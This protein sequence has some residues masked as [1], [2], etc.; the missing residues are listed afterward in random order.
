[1]IERSNLTYMSSN[2]G[3]QPRPIRLVYLI[4][5][6]PELTNTFIDREIT[7]LRRLGNFDIRIVSI[8]Y[9]RTV[10]SFSAEQKALHQ[11]TTYLLS[12]QWAKFNYLAFSASNIH[13]LFSKPLVYIKT[14][15]ELLSGSRRTFKDWVKTTFYFWQGVYAAYLLRSVPFD[16]LHV[17]FMDRAVLAALVASRL[18]KKTYSFTAHAADIYTKAAHVREKIDNA[19]FVIT[20]SKF[21]KEH[22]QEAYPGMD[23]D[24][25]H[26]LHPW[27]DLSKFAPCDTRPLHDRLHILS[28]GRLVEKKGHIDLIE[29]VLRLRA[30][31]HDFECQIA[32]EGPLR[33][34]LE[35]RIAELSLQNHVR[36][37]GGLPQDQVMG[38]LREW[39]DVFVLPCVIAKNG[40]RDGMPVS[41]AEAMAMELPVISTDIVG[42]GE[43]VQDGTGLL[44]PPHDPTALAEALRHIANQGP[45]L[46]VSMGR[47]GR[48]VVDSEFNL[49]KGTQELAGLFRRVVHERGA[50]R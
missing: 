40:D 47:K 29:A 45:P 20:V 31:G 36:L 16:H 17:H 39:A 8:R 26:V 22:F 21:N 18:L 38:L 50:N 2:N 27:I 3:H 23:A 34:E 41:I 4:G 49:L 28:V 12:P 6:Y 5:T 11:E 44:I 15:I 13:F 43:L 9:P 33:A 1:M 14:L 30:D 19:A 42:I 46:M 7:M 24:K 35:Q 37:L 10:G 25:I 32:G 48:A